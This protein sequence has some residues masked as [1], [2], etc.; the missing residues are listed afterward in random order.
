MTGADGPR[1][2]A[3]SVLYPRGGFFGLRSPMLFHGS[4]DFFDF[5]K[6]P[7]PSHLSNLFVRSFFSWY[8]SLT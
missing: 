7:A 4:F 8:P 1:R 6:L 2:S 5:R 3:L